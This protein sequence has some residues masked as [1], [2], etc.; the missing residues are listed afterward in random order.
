M[1]MT[2]G[3]GSRI[4]TTNSRSMG[5]SGMIATQMVT[6][7]TAI[8]SLRTQTSGLTPMVTGWETTAMYSQ[9]TPMS[10]QTRTEMEWVT[11]PTLSRVMPVR[12]W[13]ATG[14]GSET[15]RTASRQTTQSG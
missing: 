5:A 6:V 3:T 9:A 11:T 7:T 2:M 14:M 13:T 15:T 8:Y 10:G 12:L 4:W 1:T